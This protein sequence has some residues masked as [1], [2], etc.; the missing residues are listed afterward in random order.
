[1]SDLDPVILNF[2]YAILGVVLTITSMWIGCKVFN[3]MVCF[4][5]SDELSKGNVAVGLML[6]GMFIG[7]GTATGLVIGMGLN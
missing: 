3:H 6:A 1:M 2:I 7:I 5:I 4:E